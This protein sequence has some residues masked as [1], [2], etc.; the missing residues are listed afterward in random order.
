M[1]SRVRQ[2]NSASM[3]FLPIASMALVSIYFLAAVTPA[4]LYG[5]PQFSLNDVLIMHALTA[6]MP[7]V[8][9]TAFTFSLHI[10]QRVLDAAE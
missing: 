5:T 4:V 7:E 9:G 8:L 1:A 10:L 2:V 6:F 3:L